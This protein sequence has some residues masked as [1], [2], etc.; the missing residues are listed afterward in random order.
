MSEIDRELLRVAA[1]D[2]ELVDVQEGVEHLDG[3]KD[4]FAPATVPD[5]AAGAV[6]EPILKGTASPE[7]YERQFEVR[8]S[9]AVEEDRSPEACAERHHQLEPFAPNHREP[10]HV[11]VV[12]EAGRLP[13]GLRVQPLA[14]SLPTPPPTCETVRFPDRLL[15]RGWAL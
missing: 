12:Q 9:R 1:A 15:S 3:G 14:G 7:R 4:P 13:A 11:G 10:V 6:P 5:A 2:V 8:R